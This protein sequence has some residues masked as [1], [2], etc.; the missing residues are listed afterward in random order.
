MLDAWVIMPNHLHGIMVITDPVGDADPGGD[1]LRT[2]P[3]RRKSVGRLVGAFKTVS[4]KRINAQRGTPGAV[5]WQLH[6]SDLQTMLCMHT[7]RTTSAQ[8]SLCTARCNRNSTM[9]E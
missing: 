4:T 1:G 3:T 7:L 8:H 2:V 9:L 6:T 5:V